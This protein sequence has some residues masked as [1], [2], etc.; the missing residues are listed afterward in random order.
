MPKYNLKEHLSEL[1]SRLII[2]LVFFLISFCA[3]YYY[4]EEIFQIMLHPLLEISEIHTRKIIYTGLT[5]AFFTYLNL[6]VFA[7]FCLSIPIVALEIYLFVKP[8]LYKREARIAS[9]MFFLSP[10]L[11]IL[12]AL[13]VFYFVIPK[14]WEFFLSFEVRDT[15]LPL[16]LE[17]RI[18][19]YIALVIKLILSFGLAFQMPI[20]LVILAMFGIISHK[21][22]RQKRR[23]AIVINFVIAGIITPPDIL[24][25]IALA[26]P[27]LLLYELSIFACK[28][29]EEG[30]QNA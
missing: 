12:G 9:F 17:A 3:C 5:E 19:E 13:F 10:L 8:G 15:E 7:A 14:A 24:S 11:F 25:Q 20:I 4:S 1:K 16:M 6:S 18:S 21:S 29:I 27:M 26:I 30:K 28:Y 23:I 2:V 22:L